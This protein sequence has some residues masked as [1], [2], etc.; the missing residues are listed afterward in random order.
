[1]SAGSVA[2]TALPVVVGI[3][4]LLLQAGTYLNHDVAWVLYSAGWLLDGRTFGRDIVAANPPLIWWISELPMG[5]SRV[6]DISPIV[7][8][9]LFVAVLVG[10]SLFASDRLLRGGGASRGS[11]ALFLGVGAYLLT[12]GV[13]RDFGQ[14]EH[15]AVVLSL[16]YLLAAA[17]RLEGGGPGVAA[18]VLIG[19]AA[20]LGIALKPYFIAVP[21]LVEGALLLA[22]RSLRTLARPEAMGVLAAAAAYAVALPPFARAWI[23]ESV[24]DIARVYWAF[25]GS[26]AETIAGVRDDLLVLAVAICLITLARWPRAAT[27]L[28]LAALGFLVA[29]LAQTKGYSYHLYPIKAFALLAMVA[30]LPATERL[31][32]L[33]AGLLAL[34]L[35][36]HAA[37]AA[38]ELRNRSAG[39]VFGKSAREMTGFV[40]ANVPADGGFLAISTHPYP[41]FP[42]ALYAERRWVSP[43]NSSLFLPAVVRL[44]RGDGPEDAGLLAFAEA[45]AREAVLRD[46]ATRPSLVLIDVQPVRHAIGEDPTDFLAFY[47]EDPAFAAAWQAY[48]PIAGAPDGYTAYRRK[49][50]AAP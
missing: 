10:L 18:G 33:A 28:L 30:V 6:L 46:L 8:F 24:P 37:G 42:V 16:P 20:G 9:R 43:S 13:H 25:S 48:E 7:A 2:L 49:R 17:R 36:W 11:R 12:A 19:V 45:K 5:A 40:R 21:F 1:M 32:P 3:T 14:R 39:G 29:A 26:L 34:L 4:G 47:L 31:R 27:V 44:R 38:H 15:L 23:D 35:V 22:G 41:G 50:S